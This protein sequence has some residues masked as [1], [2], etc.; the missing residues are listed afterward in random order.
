M[1]R[2]LPQPFP[3]G[4]FSGRHDRVHDGAR[5]G[6]AN[7]W[8][9]D[10]PV[11]PGDYVGPPRG[12]LVPS[13]EADYDVAMP[14]GGWLN[15]RAGVL[16]GWSDRSGDL[17]RIR[18]DG[19]NFDEHSYGPSRPYLVSQYRSMSE[20]DRLN[21]LAAV[22][23]RRLSVHGGAPGEDADG[24][25]SLAR[26]TQARA[27]ADRVA[28]SRDPASCPCQGS[29]DRGAAR[30]R[31]VPAALLNHGG[32]VATLVGQATPDEACDVVWRLTR[33]L[34]H[35][36]RAGLM[37]AAEADARRSAERV[38]G[39]PD[40]PLTEEAV[41]M[42]AAQALRWHGPAVADRLPFWTLGWIFVASPVMDA[43]LPPLGHS[44][45][46]GLRRAVLDRADQARMRRVT[47]AWTAAHSA[48][49]DLDELR[50]LADEDVVTSAA[51]IDLREQSVPPA[52]SEPD[53]YARTV[54]SVVAELAAE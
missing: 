3:S 29:A 13:Q 12:G 25:P 16:V 42:V 38:S 49:R 54:A 14:A 9:T 11:H 50:R 43:L 27:I 37:R 48:S 23:R 10:A 45:R 30:R 8:L 18:A 34:T 47:H 41:A 22:R 32:A 6:F 40:G 26:G 52:Q 20:E 39:W 33:A 7:V 31:T 17:P 19:E 28:V 35:P 1:C 2:W 46:E 24:A 51:V 5:Q 15:V 4:A 21:A 53:D 44:R 36:A